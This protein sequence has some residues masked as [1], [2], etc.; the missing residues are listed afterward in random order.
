LPARAEIILALVHLPSKLH[1]DDDSQ[2]AECGELGRE[3]S[4]AEDQAG[5]IRTVL[6]GDFNMNPFERGMVETTGLHGTMSRT[7]AQR[8]SRIV[9][10][11]QYRFFYNP[12]WSHLGD[13]RQRAAGSY[14]Y[15]SAK[16]VNYFWNT[17]DQVLIRPDLIG[18]FDPDRLSILTKVG[19]LDL[20]RSDGR[21]DVTKFSDHLPIVFE[22]DF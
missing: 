3:I 7:I 5:H 14:Y 13:S 12:M 15:D 11:R 4:E 6:V 9:Q 16:H 21:P 1:W 2:S 8:Q 22:L 20:V 19:A 18:G 17:F 10:D